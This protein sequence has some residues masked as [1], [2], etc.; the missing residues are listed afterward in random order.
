MDFTIYALKGSSEWF[1][2]LP[3]LKNG[4][5][6]FGWSYIESADLRKL[7]QRVDTDG[8]DSLSD[9][10]KDCYQAFL[11]DSSLTTMSSI[12]MF[13]NGGNVPLPK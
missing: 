10:E 8:W 5:G 9:E 4:E 1:D 6:R 3:S 12:S 2:I 11:L 13:Q 7:K